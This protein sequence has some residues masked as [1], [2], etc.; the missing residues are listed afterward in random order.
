MEARARVRPE[1]GSGLMARG[2]RVVIKDSGRLNAPEDVRFSLSVGIHPEDGSDTHVGQDEDLTV[3]DIAT[4]HEFG[5]E[6]NHV[7]MRSWCRAWFD[8]N[9]EEV[10]AQVRTALAA[11][12]KKQSW[13]K[14]AALNEV[15]R[16]ARNSMVGRIAK[17]IDPPLAASTIAKKAPKVIPLI[18]S[19]QMI[20]TISAQLKSAEGQSDSRG[21]RIAWNYAARAGKA[22]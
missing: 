8:E 6:D 15:T 18:D 5:S 17:R 21:R 4:I 20:D 3:A 13:A 16:K 2:S 19:R 22:K 10:R 7:P 9:S 14:A 11:M 1:P 12:A